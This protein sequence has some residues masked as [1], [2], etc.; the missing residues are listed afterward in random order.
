MTTWV[1][2]AFL[3][4][5]VV[6]MALSPDYRTA[7]VVGPV[8]VALLLVAFELKSRRRGASDTLTD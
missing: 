1:V 5:V 7:V 2:L 4:G 6:L 8:W 3:A